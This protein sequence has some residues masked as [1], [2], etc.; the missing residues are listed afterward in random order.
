MPQQIFGAEAVVSMVNRA[1]ANTSPANA[2]FKNQVAAAGTTEASQYTYAAQ[3]GAQYA[4]GKTPAELS[5][6]L[7]GNMGVANEVL[8]SALTDYIAFH[9]A[10][11]I[12]VI[13]LQLGQIL[14]GLEGDAT[15]GAAAAAWNQEVTNAYTYSSNPA[16]TTPVDDAGGNGS[17]FTL[18]TSVDNI[19]GTAGDDTIIGG[20]GSA[21]GTST[22]GSADVI[23]G[24]AGTDTFKVTTEGA[25]AVAITPNLKAVEK[26]FVQALTT[27]VGTTAN[28]VNATG[29]KEIW[30]ERSTDALT[31]T[32]VQELAAVGVK[33]DIGAN[34]YRVGFKDSLASGVADSVTVALDG[35]VTTGGLGFGGMTAANEFET[36]NI[37]ATGTNSINALQ[38]ATG[39]ALAATKTVNVTGAGKVTVTNALAG[40]V[41]TVDASANTGGVSFDLSATGAVKATGGA[42]NDTF[43]LGASLTTADVLVGGEGTDIIGVTEGNTLAT[44]LQVTGFETLDVGGAGGSANAFDVS[45]LS[46]ITTLKVGSATVAANAVT[47]NNLAKGAG[48][49]INAALGNALN[50]NVKD[51]GAGSPNDSIAVLVKGATAITT[52]GQLA[53]KDIETVTLTADKST[54]TGNV[55]H[56]VSDLTADQA[57]TVKV[58]NGNAGL[59]ITDLNAK[60]LVLF[61]AAE[62]T[63]AVSVTTTGGTAFT[64]TNGVAFKLG[65][66]AD[67]LVLT[68]STTAGGDFF[69]TGGTGGDAITLTAAAAEVER[70]IY[71]AAGESNTGVVAG[72]NQ[73]DR[74]TNFTKAEDKIDLKAFG[75]TGASVSA[76]KVGAAADINAATGELVAGKAANFFGAGADMRSVVI[77]DDTADTWV[78]VDA[79]KDGSFNAGDLAIEL[80]GLTGAGV[81]ALTDFI[82]A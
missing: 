12:G 82:F 27:A 23:N 68:G 24:G 53:L 39:G 56:I 16:N 28:L 9:G 33:G 10:Q 20:S 22:L 72:V 48:V 18:T 76:L 79:N 42:G 59:T 35:A 60:A 32:N 55:T 78:Y 6:L 70:V 11:N 63:Q 21:G 43:K 40:T 66:G 13:A 50:I 81:P 26:L 5:A 25:A 17:T 15:F 29:V 41:T 30:N 74:I 44:G 47:V 64:A 38:N 37:A 3:L 54:A 8:E 2:V 58:A 45:K 46:G 49:E 34:A 14:A 80:A 67:T 19:V 4:V 69:I 7:L 1:L 73:F 31:V 36:I 51:A 65:A 52:T 75:F 71:T 57:L 61:D 77:V 62:A